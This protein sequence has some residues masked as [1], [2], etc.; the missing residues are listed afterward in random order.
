MD[1]KDKLVFLL[2]RSNTI[3]FDRIR[4]LLHRRY[5]WIFWIRLI[6]FQWHKLDE[7]TH[8]ITH[9]DSPSIY[10]RLL[11]YFFPGSRHG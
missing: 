6:T 2:L 9:M 10:C 4:S 8:Y 5:S 11:A 7:A 3:K 1:E